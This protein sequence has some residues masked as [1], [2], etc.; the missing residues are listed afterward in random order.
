MLTGVKYENI[1]DRGLTLTTGEGKR[2]TIK[3][4]TIVLAAGATPD[5]ELFQTLQ[6]K[7]EEIYRAGDCIQPRR[8]L[9]A[10]QEG[11]AIGR[12]I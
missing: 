9:D 2:L 6:G 8:M 1:S 11:S 10:M 12:R 3:A 4:D 5:T 7:V